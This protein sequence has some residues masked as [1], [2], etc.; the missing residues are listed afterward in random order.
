MDRQHE[1]KKVFHNLLKGVHINSDASVIYL[2]HD[3]RWDK[4]DPK[5]YRSDLEGYTSEIVDDIENPDQVKIVFAPHFLVL[6]FDKFLVS[7]VNGEK[8][9]DN[10]LFKKKKKGKDGDYYED[11]K[12]I[13]LEHVDDVNISGN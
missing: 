5:E 4:E 7:I 13:T 10:I 11:Y 6:P 2:K 8:G 3:T 12:K 9:D 1:P